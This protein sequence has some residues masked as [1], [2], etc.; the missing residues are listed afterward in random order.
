MHKDW[1]ALAKGSVLRARR[2]EGV[3]WAPTTEAPAT[4][5][6]AIEAEAESELTKACAPRSRVGPVTEAVATSNAAIGIEAKQARSVS[7][8]LGL[9][10]DNRKWQ[11]C[12]HDAGLGPDTAR[13][14]PHKLLCQG[15]GQE[16]HESCHGLKCLHCFVLLGDRASK[17]AP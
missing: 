13:Y 8:L 7:S 2:E 1:S 5:D 11:A 14:R 6:A 3:G 16:S 15:A 17:W 10:P 4:S 9:V 12:L